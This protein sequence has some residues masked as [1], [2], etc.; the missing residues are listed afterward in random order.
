M[1]SSRWTWI[2]ILSKSLLRGTHLRNQAKR[3]NEMTKRMLERSLQK[4]P[5]KITLRFSLM[6]RPRRL[7]M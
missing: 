1:T 3:A 2:T 4:I 5:M 6:R 7:M